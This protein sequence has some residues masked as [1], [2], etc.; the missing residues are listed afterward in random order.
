MNFIL[1]VA[2]VIIIDQISKYVVV[3][4]FFLGESV[5]VI[6]DIFHWTYILNQGAAF[7]MLEGSR[8][9]FIVIALAVSVGIWYFRGE[10]GKEPVM[11][12][13]GAALF[14]GGA[15][16]NLIDRI[17]R[18]AVIDFFDFRIWPIFNVADI[19]I[20]IGVGMIL[21]KLITAEL[22]ERRNA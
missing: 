9:L 8:W 7:G 18:G 2:A 12:R 19:A 13:F 16:G 5:P 3:K 11:V 20:C 15:V 21:W 6:P 4:N 10:I 17:L 14:A 22:L 1:I